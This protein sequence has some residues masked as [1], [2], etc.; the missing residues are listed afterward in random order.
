MFEEKKKQFSKHFCCFF[1]FVDAVKKQYDAR[2]GA[3]FMLV[4]KYRI[5]KAWWKYRNFKVKS[6]ILK[7]FL[8]SLEMVFFLIY[9]K[10]KS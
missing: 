8:P 9:A 5:G 2:G 4:L 7:K 6:S 3:V 1:L 10:K